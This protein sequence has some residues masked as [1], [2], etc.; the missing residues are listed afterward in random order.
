M[1]GPGF[2]EC[3]SKSSV[4]LGK[5][6]GKWKEKWFTRDKN[7]A[8]CKRPRVQASGKDSWK[9]LDQCQ[10]KVKTTVT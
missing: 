10:T 8:V 5:G 7:M 1:K 2:V 4:G 9:L 6:R 3:I